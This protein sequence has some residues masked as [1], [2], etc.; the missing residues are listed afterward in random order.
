MICKAQIVELK[1][2]FQLKCRNVRM[3]FESEAQKT[4]SG[5]SGIFFCS[6]SLFNKVNKGSLFTCLA[7]D[8]SAKMFIFLLMLPIR[9]LV[10]V[11]PS[12]NESPASHGQFFKNSLTL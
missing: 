12:N 7:L 5:V 3:W 9:L 4:I 8:E 2:K 11:C 10:V 6:V 1:I